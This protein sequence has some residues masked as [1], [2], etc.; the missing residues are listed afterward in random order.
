MFLHLGKEIKQYYISKFNGKREKVVDLLLL[1]EWGKHHFG[2]I[3][4]RSRLLSML[5]SDHNEREHFC[6]YCLHSFHSEE[7]CSKHMEYCQDHDFCHVKMPEEDKKWLMY[8]DGNKESSDYHLL[9]L[10]ILNVY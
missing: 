6:I 5:N 4:D 7:A 10:L 3:K 1:E 8:Q 2:A 9:L